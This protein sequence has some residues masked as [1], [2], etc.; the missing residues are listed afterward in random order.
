ML[1]GSG[2]RSSPRCHLSCETS[3]TQVMN[4]ERER[5]H[6]NYCMPWPFWL[7]D[8]LIFYY[9]LIFFIFWSFSYYFD[10]KWLHF[11]FSSSS[12]FPISSFFVHCDL[13][14]LWF[15]HSPIALESIILFPRELYYDV[16]S[17]WI[18]MQ[19]AV[20]YPS[21]CK[22]KSIYI[23]NWLRKKYNIFVSVFDLSGSNSFF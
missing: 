1:C 16:Y 4:R 9:F 3:G 19:N 15:I 10:S 17:Y 12:S 22:F 21:S 2:T 18:L 11:L 14:F 8:W 20:I 5:K 13:I 23:M 6:P 7:I